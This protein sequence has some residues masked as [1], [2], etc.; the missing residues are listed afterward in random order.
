M[1]IGGDQMNGEETL[2]L[3]SS[4]KPTI[5]GAMKPGIEAIALVTPYNVP[6]NIMSDGSQVCTKK[7][8]N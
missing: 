2:T 7:M 5:M 3:E 1:N 6:E 8:I 4:I